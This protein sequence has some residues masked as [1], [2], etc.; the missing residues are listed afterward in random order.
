MKLLVADDNLAMRRIV[1]R[2]L[3]KAGLQADKM[4]KVEDGKEAM[5]I[6]DD[7]QP[8]IITSDFGTDRMDG[9]DFLVEVKDRYPD[10]IF[11]FI[12]SQVSP[13]LKQK[14]DQAGADFYLIK[15]FTVG[16][17][18]SVLEGYSI[19]ADTF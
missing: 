17:L 12:T 9:Y 11:G 1:S 6:I 7:F 5:K 18:R 3:R 14:A 13:E 8:D 15:P 2:T 19:L 16:G 4:K 10:V